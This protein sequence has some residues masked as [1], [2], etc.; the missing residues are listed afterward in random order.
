MNGEVWEWIKSIA[1]AVILALIIRFFVVEV[2][3]VDGKSMLPTIRDEERLIVNKFLYLFQEPQKG[4]VIIFRYTSERDFIKRVIGTAGD[5]IRIEDG[6]VYLNDLALTEDYILEPPRKD[7]G[8]VT[9]PEGYFFVMGDNRN[10]SMDSR[11][12]EVGMITKERIK[13]KAFV[14]FWPVDGIRLITH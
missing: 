14:V 4:D 6:K 9:V 13:G 11:A 3:V 2:F 10:E 12:P 8:P 7:Y 1:I 5:E